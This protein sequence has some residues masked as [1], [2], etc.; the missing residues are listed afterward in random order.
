LLYKLVFCF[1]V[2]HSRL[3]NFLLLSRLLVLKI[4]ADLSLFMPHAFNSNSQFNICVLYL[5][6]LVGQTFNRAFQQTIAVCRQM[7]VPAK[8]IL[9]FF[10]CHLHRLFVIGLQNLNLALLVIFQFVN[11]SLFFSKKFV[12]FFDFLVKSPLFESGLSV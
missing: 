12:Y 8:F 7:I 4:K 1:L 6:Q 3:E 10:D 11:F 9:C 5:L 2:V